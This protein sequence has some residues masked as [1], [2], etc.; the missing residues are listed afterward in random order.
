VQL[1]GDLVTALMLIG[2]PAP[3]SVST[4]HAS[5]LDWQSMLR[6]LTSLRIIVTNKYC[7]SLASLE[8]LPKSLHHVDIDMQHTRSAQEGSLRLLANP[9]WLPNLISKP[10]FF[11]DAVEL[12][13]RGPSLFQDVH[14]LARLYEIARI[15][16]KWEV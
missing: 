14:E 2:P 7:M 4:R 12:V 11:L 16:R 13:K 6:A 8:T 15:A 10:R 5:T 3:L 9:A 1:L